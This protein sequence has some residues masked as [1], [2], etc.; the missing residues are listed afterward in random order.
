MLLLQLQTCTIF[1]YKEVYSD[2]ETSTEKGRPGMRKETMKPARRC[3]EVNIYRSIAKY[4]LLLLIVGRLQ[5]HWLAI[6]TVSTSAWVSQVLKLRAV[7]RGVI[8]FTS[9]LNIVQWETTAGYNRLLLGA[10]SW[11]TISRPPVIAGD[12]QASQIARRG[13]HGGR[14]GNTVTYTR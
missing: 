11:L 2:K 8:L 12:G 5:S 14:L 4:V 13:N 3:A 7:F 6:T 1:P 10:V 9:H